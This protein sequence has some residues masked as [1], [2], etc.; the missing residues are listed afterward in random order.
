VFTVASRDESDERRLA[1]FAVRTDPSRICL[2]G[3][4]DG[5][6]QAEAAVT[7]QQR[8]VEERGGAP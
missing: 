4:F 6:S 2:L 7:S 8:C 3:A 5:R 1:Y